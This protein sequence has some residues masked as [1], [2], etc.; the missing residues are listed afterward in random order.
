MNDA[1]AAICFPLVNVFDFDSD[2]MCE[3]SSGMADCLSETHFQSFRSC[4][5]CSLCR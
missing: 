5:M 4:F 1:G 3:K 2:F